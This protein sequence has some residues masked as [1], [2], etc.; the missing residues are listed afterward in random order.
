MRSIRSLSIG[1]L[2]AVAMAVVPATASAAASWQSGP[3]AESRVVDCNTSQQEY[4]VGTYLS[5]FADPSNPP[6]T[7]QTYYV[8]IDMQSIGNP[9]AGTYADPNLIL[10]AGTTPAVNSSHPVICYVQFPNNNHQTSYQRDTQDCPQSLRQVY[11]PNGKYGYSLDPV[12]ANPPFWPLAYLW[13]DNVPYMT[14]E[15]QVPV[16]SSTPL[17]GSSTLDGY[18]RLADG[19]DNPTLQPNLLMIVNQSGSQ[20]VGGQNKQISVLYPN[21]SINSNTQQPNTSTTVGIVGYVE[22]NSNP[23]YA[24]AELR[25][26]SPQGDCVNPGAPVYTT[27]SANLQNPQTQITGVFTGLYADVAYCWRLHATVTNGPQQGDYYGNWQ[28]FITNGTYHSYLNEPPPANAPGASTC[29]N[30]GNNCSTSNCSTSTCATTGTLSSSTYDLRVVLAGNG[31]GKVTGANGISCP[32]VCRHTYPAGSTA[33][34]TLTATPAAGS[35]FAGWSGGGC[36]GTTKTCSLNL[37]AA[38]TVTARFASTVC[39]VPN[40]V[41]MKLSAA[42]AAIKA[43]GCK[44]GKVKKKTKHGKKGVVL[45]EKPKAGKV[46]ALGTKVKLVV[47]K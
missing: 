4:G 39:H 15:I 10:P 12:N 45:S 28:F 35:R 8:A 13:E 22:N 2:V 5:Y 14:I 33:S 6:Q 3:L 31:R 34:T 11:L 16:K 41:G 47:G 42:E 21:P 32:R 7:G 38:R 24:V 26:A 43:A 37:S 17:D 46:V 23:G 36:S 40:V 30:T 1:M 27:T 9:C 44:V 20:N 29:A 19:Q 25:Y 18:V